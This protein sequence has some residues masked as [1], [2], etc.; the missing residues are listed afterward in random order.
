[1]KNHDPQQEEASAVKTSLLSEELCL[2]FFWSFITKCCGSF[3]LFT[4]W[5][6]SP[7]WG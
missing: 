6:V 7:G 4:P 1:M 3:V 2:G 5:D